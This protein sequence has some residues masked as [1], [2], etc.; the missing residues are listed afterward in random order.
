MAAIDATF[1][2]VRNQVALRI[3]QEL[4]ARAEDK[5]E[6]VL[7]V[8]ALFPVKAQADEI[9]SQPPINLWLG[10]YPTL[11]ELEAGSEN[12]G[13]VFRTEFGVSGFII[14]QRVTHEE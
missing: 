3:E 2:I 8:I 5:A 1:L 9:V 14:H 6:L 7:V 10:E 13:A 12:A 11:L 4:V